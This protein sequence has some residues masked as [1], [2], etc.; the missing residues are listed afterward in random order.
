MRNSFAL[1]VHRLADLHVPQHG[2]AVVAELPV[3]E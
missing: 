3:K 2:A 1:H